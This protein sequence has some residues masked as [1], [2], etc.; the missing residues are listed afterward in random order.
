METLGEIT[1]IRPDLISICC[2]I[3]S[4]FSV[5][6][7]AIVSRSNRSLVLVDIVDPNV[8]PLV[9]KIAQDTGCSPRALVL[10][11]R[12]VLSAGPG[13]NPAYFLS[14]VG[15]D[16]PILMHPRDVERI[17][18]VNEQLKFEDPTK[19]AFLREC[20]ITV[21]HFPGHTEGSILLWLPN[22]GGAL[23]AGDGCTVSMK[24]NELRV[25]RVPAYFSK[26]DNE[27]RERWTDL[28][29]ET[30]IRFT[31]LAP[32]HGKIAANLGSWEQM[33]A[34]LGSLMTMEATI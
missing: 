34:Q 2:G 11:H 33:K 32:L 12:H 14:K 3:D 25:V 27:I 29:K 1:A 31:T 6:G 26:N 19:S 30:E 21:I 17:S 5:N 28:L 16:A 23:L 4:G 13:S 8:I 20:G 15:I 24:G 10:S 18:T 7:Y 22:N 9:L